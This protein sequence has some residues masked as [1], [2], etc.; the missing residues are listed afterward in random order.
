MPGKPKLERPFKT[1]GRASGEAGKLRRA[2][3][4]RIAEV[5]KPGASPKHKREMAEDARRAIATYKK[6]YKRTPKS[7]F[8]K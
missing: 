6:V 2:Y 1:R 4:A 8:K 3:R 7:W 5:R